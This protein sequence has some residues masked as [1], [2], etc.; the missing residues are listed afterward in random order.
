LVRGKHP[1]FANRLL[2]DGKIESLNLARQHDYALQRDISAE[3]MR[4]DDVRISADGLW[5]AVER[6]I[7]A[8]VEVAGFKYA[9]RQTVEDLHVDEQNISHG[10]AIL[11]IPPRIV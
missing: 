5:L 7:P 1:F 3:G 9:D 6:F 10:A 8:I 2:G 4:Q 11:F